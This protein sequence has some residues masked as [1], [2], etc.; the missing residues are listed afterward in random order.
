MDRQTQIEI[1]AAA[2][3]TLRNHLME[4]RKDVQ[5]IDM[6]NLAGFCRNCLSRWMQEAANERG[7]EMT[8]E[9]AREIFYGM[10]Y[11]DWKAQHQTEASDDQK[12]AFDKSFAENVGDKG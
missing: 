4:D 6:M 11:D 8:K 2:F 9:Q 3:R 1:E 7:F 10:P 5:N 12:A